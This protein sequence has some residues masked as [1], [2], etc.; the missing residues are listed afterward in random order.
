MSWHVRNDRRSTKSFDLFAF[1]Q[2]SCTASLLQRKKIFHTLS[3]LI[4]VF[5]LDS[6]LKIDY[7]VT[8][9]T[10]DFHFHLIDDSI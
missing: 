5:P 6:T 7:D 10:F 2:S 1:R 8:R 3:G 4:P 9:S